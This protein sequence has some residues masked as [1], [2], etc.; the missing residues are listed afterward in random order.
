MA[1]KNLPSTYSKEI[2]S[3][4]PY[5]RSIATVLE[6]YQLSSYTRFLVKVNFR[7]AT[8][9]ANQKHEQGREVKIFR[10]HVGGT[11]YTL[12]INLGPS[13]LD[14][15]IYH[16][17]NW[18]ILESFLDALEPTLALEPTPSEFMPS[19]WE[20]RRETRGS[21]FRFTELPGEIRNRI[22]QYAA[23]EEPIAY[24]CEYLHLIF[25]TTKGRHGKPRLPPHQRLN[26]AL[27]FVNRQL[28][29]EYAAISYEQTRFIF[30]D[31]VC[32]TQFLQI[33]KFKMPSSIRHLELAFP[34][35]IDYLKFFGAQLARYHRW[36]HH[37]SAVALYEWER[38]P[39]AKLTMVIPDPQDVTG[40]RGISSDF[41][42]R[43][44]EGCYKKV[45]DWILMAAEEFIYEIPVEFKGYIKNSQKAYFTK[46]YRER[47]ES[48]LA[49][50]ED[51]DPEL[52]HYN[53]EIDKEEGGVSLRG[54]E[55]LVGQSLGFIAKDLDE[56]K[57]REKEFQE[58][59][60]LGRFKGPTKQL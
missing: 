45:V 49:C 24:P 25:N 23:G 59:G 38:H 55:R 40:H 41:L 21:Y 46:K 13:D 22:Y 7:A 28:S 1:W 29:S 35:H 3:N 47:H 37:N 32:L 56:S 51:M 4:C 50:I 20:Y 52:D 6:R 54:Y 15:M 43:G 16:E 33:F 39:L 17:G 44:D 2:R 42:Q 19:W 9:L 12:P 58:Y 18:E 30:R 8:S 26:T 48:E 10:F 11:D 5:T 27:L 31:P 34:K 60:Y 57:E 14:V 53:R 36:N